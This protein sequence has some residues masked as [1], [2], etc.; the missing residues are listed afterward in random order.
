MMN[1]GLEAEN[2]SS[3][4]TKGVMDRKWLG[5]PMGSVNNE[6]WVPVNITGEREVSASVFAT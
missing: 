6:I 5:G 2:G 3:G 1:C 4:Y